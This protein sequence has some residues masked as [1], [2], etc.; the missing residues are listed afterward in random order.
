MPADIKSI[1]MLYKNV[2]FDGWHAGVL[3]LL[4][5]GQITQSQ[6]AKA[7][8]V[9]G[10]GFHR[11]LWLLSL[12]CVEH[13]RYG[14]QTFVVP[15]EMQGA[16]SR[17]SLSEVKGEDLRFPYPATYFA[18]PDYDGEIWG[19]EDTLWHKVRGVFVWFEQ[20]EREIR[21]PTEV[22]VTPE[23]DKGVIHLYIWGAENERSRHPGDDASLWTALDLNEMARESEDL[24][25][26]LE[27]VLRDPSREK[28][29]FKVNPELANKLGFTFLSQT[30]ERRTKQEDTVI[31]TLRIL[32]N[33]LLYID[34]DGAELDED[35][36]S[37]EA[38]EKYEQI[39]QQ[40]GRIKSEGKRKK[41]QRKLDKL[42]TDTVTWVGRSVRY[43]SDSVDGDGSGTPQKRHWVRG[44]WWPKRVTI[45]K[46]IEDARSGIVGREKEHQ[47]LRGLVVDAESPED[48]SSHLIRLSAL[49][50]EIASMR[51]DA[52]VLAE[53]MESKRRWVM[54]YKKGTRGKEPEDRT[55]V[56]GS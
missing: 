33:S 49:R 23:N 50:A 38:R 2:P 6:A 19:G 28:V 44:H 56:L 37:V 22:E 3:N 51:K 26:Y 29:D 32:F 18:L 47:I 7:F 8:D 46:R 30:G 41:A 39:T 31:D 9:P 4:Q 17:T 25:S 15:K 5:S 34:S 53:R 21:L 14:Q 35:P 13:K 42:P 36:S 54:P 24:E 43:D 20:G 55:Y 52:E 45:R 11:S 27:R 1:P 16:L 10:I 12:H 48:T 40:L